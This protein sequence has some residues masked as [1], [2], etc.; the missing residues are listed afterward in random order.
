MKHTVTP[1]PK[2][3]RRNEP[4][5]NSDG[6]RPGTAGSPYISP[7]AQQACV[8]CV[9]SGRRLGAP[10]RTCLPKWRLGR[11]VAEAGRL[12]WPNSLNEE[13]NG[14]R[15]NHSNHHHEEYLCDACVLR[16]KVGAQER[17]AG[18]HEHDC[19]PSCLASASGSLPADISTKSWS[20]LRA[21]PLYSKRDLCEHSQCVDRS[22]GLMPTV[23]ALV[24]QL[25]IRVLAEKSGCSQP[26]IGCARIRS[27]QTGR[28]P[29]HWCRGR[30]SDPSP[31]VAQRYSALNRARHGLPERR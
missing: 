14:Q 6:S 5:S 3:Y 25:Q 27:D 2:S 26:E 31:L 12:G 17:R 9:T 15:C 18:G 16:V 13:T 1:V 11:I 21:A 24:V 23:L 20:W 19:R 10:T 7:A 8:L 30:T 4:S 22:G 29:H 28:S